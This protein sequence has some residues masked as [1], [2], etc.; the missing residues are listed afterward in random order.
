MSP[1]LKYLSGFGNYF[2]TEALPGTLPEGQNSPQ[3]VAH[4]LYA[5]QL[6]GSPFTVARVENRRSW[7]YRIRPA[8]LHSEFVPI[9]DGLVRSAPFDEISASPNQ[10]RWDPFPIPAE[11]TDF[12][13]GLISL[14]GNG[15][16]ADRRGCAVHIYVSN[17]LMG[18][19]FFYCADGDLLV[20]PEQGGL[21][22]R[23]ELGILEVTPGEIAVVPRGIRFQADPTE[24]TAR[25]YLCENYGAYFRP[26]D[27]GPIGSNGLAAPRD[28]LTPV[29]A[30]EDKTGKFSLIAKFQGQLW[31]AIL[32]HSPL[33]V[34][35]WH[36]N[37]APFK[38]DL[39]RF[40][41]VNTVSVDHSDPSIF[42]VLTS[43]SEFP[44][45]ANI[46]FV[47]FPPR[48]MVSDHSFT[49]V[50]PPQRDERVHGAHSRRIRR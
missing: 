49:T 22:I 13:Q 48:W 34:V 10:M 11:P 7:L 39:A 33:D 18:D 38:Y 29:A 25:G 8:L 43:P 20:V 2:S 12:V 17:H 44:G 28:F 50:L 26:P 46:D 19:R 32:D 4:G 23:T 24:G 45:V 21:L 9:E 35:A 27:L 47:I 30:Y 31:E 5:E 36:G 6:S 15:S 42:T 41:V 37:Y 14:M 16:V 40:Q 1:D 3:H